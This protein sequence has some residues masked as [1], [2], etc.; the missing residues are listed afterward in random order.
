MHLHRIVTRGETALSRRTI[1]VARAH[2]GTPLHRLSFREQGLT[3]TVGVTFLTL[4]VGCAHV[5][6]SSRPADK[7]LASAGYVFSGR[8]VEAQPFTNETAEIT[9]KAYLA[10]VRDIHYQKAPF[11]DQKGKLVTVIDSRA[12]LGI[13]REYLLYTEPVMFGK[14]IAVSLLA[15]N[16]NA[17][18]D[19]DR[20]KQLKDGE[21]REAM[22]ERLK[23]A[24]VVVSG[25]VASVRPFDQGRQFD[26]EHLPDLQLA[27]LKVSQLLK[28]NVN[29]NEV[30]FLFA[31]SRDVHWFRAPKF[32][33]GDQ[34][35]FLLKRA[36]KEVEVFRISPRQLTLFD[37]RDFQP[38]EKLETIKQ[39][40]K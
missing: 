19:P 36:G 13:G 4:L 32:K 3:I 9:T 12:T 18:F 27:T 1:R 17:R 30:A 34:G 16:E 21:E 35:I 6:T 25:S 2:A 23:E 8:I 26:T 31:A 40:L 33:Q 28:G 15:A 11:Q 20:M 5:S 29:T 7:A 22:K 14:G 38:L 37:P 24:A 10:Q 39:L